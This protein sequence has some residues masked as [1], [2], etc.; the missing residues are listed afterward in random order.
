MTAAG[1]IAILVAMI[2]ILIRALMGPTLYDRVL[3]V[4]AFGSMTVLVLGLLGF[5]M[6]RPDFLDIAMLYTLINFVSTIAILKF[7]RYRSFQVPLVRK[8]ETAPKG[9]GSNG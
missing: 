6:G 8:A 4:N 7:F 9:D 1:L 2:L 3:S 5:V